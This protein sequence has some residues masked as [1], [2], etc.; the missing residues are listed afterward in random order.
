MGYGSR[1]LS[2]LQN[3]YSN[4]IQ[5]LEEDIVE[6]N[7]ITVEDENLGLLKEQIGSVLL[8]FNLI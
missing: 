8:Y 3:Y 5:C 7:I 2:L 6:E 4:K 1:A